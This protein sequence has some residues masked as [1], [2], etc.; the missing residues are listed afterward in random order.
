MID[1]WSLVTTDPYLP[2]TFAFFLMLGIG[3]IEAIGLGL[4]ELPDFHIHFDH[5]A[6]G[7]SLLG[8]L[9]FGSGVPVLIWLTSLLACFTLTGFIGQQIVTAISGGPFTHTLP[10]IGV[11]V[12][13]LVVNIFTS[14]G[15]RHIMPKEETS[16]LD[17]EDLLI[18]RG[19]IVTSPAARH[20]PSRVKIIDRF[21]QAHFLPVE[22]HDEGD[23]LPVGETVLLVR[24]EGSLFFAQPETHSLL[25]SI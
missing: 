2:F 15:L 8:W 3:F 22:P 6:E 16:A 11:G 14:N 4:G 13:A 10:F 7:V 5:D 19:Q 25:R 21:G 1:L 9:G 24:R 12:I 18:Y 20:H 23:V 17:P